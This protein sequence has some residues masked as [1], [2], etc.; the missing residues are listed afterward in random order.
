M[1][2]DMPADFNNEDS[3]QETQLLNDTEV[4]ALPSPR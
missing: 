2:D 1:D 3:P 4:N